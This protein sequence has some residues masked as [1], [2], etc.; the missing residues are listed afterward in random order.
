MWK[1]WSQIGI[2]ATT[3]FIVGCKA[4]SIQNFTGGSIDTSRINHNLPKVANFKAHPDRNSVALT[5]NQMPRMGGY[6]IQR[7]DPEGHVWEDVATIHNPFKSIYVDTDLRPNTLYTYRILAFT[8]K[9]IAGPWSRQV[10]VRTLPPPTQIIPIFAQPV[11]KGV[12]KIIWRPHPN[13]R[14][15]KYIIQRYDD[16][17]ARWEEIGELEP[18]FNVEFVDTGLVD[19]KIYKY[20]I[21][22][23][24]F[25]NLKSYP[26]KVIQ[27]STFPRPPVVLNATATIDR[28]RQILLKWSP[29]PDVKGYKIYYSEGATGPFQLLGYSKTTQYVDK[30]PKDGFKRYYK[31]TAVS[32]F[33]TESLL[34]KTPIVMGETL[35]KPARPFVATNRFNNIIQF[36]MTSP[37]DRAVKYLIV[38]TQKMDMFNKKVDKF[39]VNS[40][41]FRDQVNPSAEYIYQIYAVDGNGVKSEPAVV[42]VEQ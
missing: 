30:I 20:R 33:G 24:T 28:P 21:I 22:A 26:S 9:E 10:K 40:N 31:V 42:K 6:Y 2:I 25:D 34:N 19:G 17:N 23:L 5:W 39:A 27:I 38:R 18:R 8:R 13:E 41:K 35:P 15:A 4:P 37:D 7:W 12:V 36:V 3:F 11:G 16:S 29:L 32:Q 1:R 14:V